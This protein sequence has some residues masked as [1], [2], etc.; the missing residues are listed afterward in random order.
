MLANKL[1]SQVKER[2]QKMTRAAE[3][4]PQLALDLALCIRDCMCG[5][6]GVLIYVGVCASVCVCACEPNLWPATVTFEPTS[7][8]SFAAS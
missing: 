6:V 2:A 8:V 5:C 3:S 4:E 1:D 7:F